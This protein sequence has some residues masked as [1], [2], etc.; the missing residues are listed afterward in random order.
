MALMPHNR[1]AA[2]KLPA[3]V[4]AETEL[5]SELRAYVEMVTEERIAAGMP[6]DEARRTALA[7]FGG[8]EQVKQAVRD[9]R[10]GAGLELIGRDLRFGFRQLVRNPGFTL[11]VVITLA[12][13]IGANT[14]IFSILNALLLKSLPYSHPERMGAIFA[15]Y[16]GATGVAEGR[17]DLDG[18]QWE[19]L[20]DN[21]PSLISAISGGMSTGANLQ[22]GQNVVYVHDARVS[23]RYLD[24][25]DIPLLLGRNFSHDEDLPHGPNAAILSYSLWR[26]SFGGDRSIV[27]RPILLKGESYTVIGVL[28]RGAIT[29]VN[30][31]V[32]TPLQPSRTGEGM[33]SNFE[34]IVRLRDGA[35]WQQADAELGHA[36]AAHIASFASR[37]PGSHVV[38]HLVP[39]QKGITAT[40]R[41]Q[42]I[43]LMLAA[44]FIL[45]IACAN[46]AGL[47]LVRMARRA[48]EIATRL[49][50]GASAWQIQRQLW[51]EN[52]MLA[53]LGGAAGVGVGFAAL[54][55]FLSLLPEDF[56]PVQSVPLYARVLGFTLAVTLLTSALFG[57]LPA[58][59]VR[60]VDLRSSIASRT[61]ASVEKLRLRQVLIGGEVA[62]SVVLLAGAG[63][64]IHARPPRNIA[65]GLR[66]RERDDGQ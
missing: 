41:P 37:N 33:G 18:E 66:F 21:V 5:D 22:S 7:E 46:L 15:R 36:W 49:A 32:F 10:A 42:A 62:L 19:G 4:Q 17:N 12:L 29:P 45:L 39:L 31:D 50:L 38:F 55:A 48:A 30:A 8:M 13:A 60:K 28:P 20:R 26:N 24:V 64:L 40:L 65:A 11:T 35:N 27:G 58:L 14:A 16:V 63:L 34:P 47:T 9:K 3:R 43:A 61:L 54:R 23:A 52:L 56:L 51:I 57:M 6:A 44:G 25:L 1:T 53:C 59:A 2:R